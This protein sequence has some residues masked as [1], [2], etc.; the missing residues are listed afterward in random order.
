[1]EAFQSTATFFLTI[2]SF[3]ELFVFLNRPSSMLESFK[4]VN[5]LTFKLSSNGANGYLLKEGNKEDS[6]LWAGVEKD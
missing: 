6:L 4:V 2:D 1:M 5:F 3:Y